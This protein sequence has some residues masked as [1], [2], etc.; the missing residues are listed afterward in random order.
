MRG[1]SALGIGAWGIVLAAALVGQTPSGSRDWNGEWEL[2]T[3]FFGEP[4]AERLVLKVEKGKV[5]GTLRHAGKSLPI[6]GTAGVGGDSIRFEYQGEDGS[7][8][9]YEGKQ[10]AAGDLA[11]R[12]T[13]MGGESWG[14]N[15]PRNWKARRAPVD[16]PAAPRTL[17]FEPIGFSRVFSA[18]VPPVLRIWPGD[19]VRTRTV[20]AAGVD[21]KNTTRALGGNPQTGP[22]YV[23]GAMPGDVL[24]VHVRKLGLNRATAISDNGLVDRAVTN[25]YAAEHKDDEQWKDVVWSLD[26]QRGVATLAKPPAR[27]KDLSV[28]LHPMLG[29][30]GVAPGFG[31]AAIRTGDSGR[32]GGNMD[33]SGIQEG[34]TVYLPVAQPGAL[35]YVGDGHALQG[36]G[37]LNGNALETSLDVE[38]TVDLIRE[39]SISAPRIED[40][41]SL[42]AIGLEGSLDEA[43]R[44]ATSALA[45]WLQQDYQLTGPETA[46]L[47][48]A[49]I[50][51]RIA[52]VADRNVGVVARIR[53]NRIPPAPPASP[54]TPT[55]APGKKR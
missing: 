37:E 44:E 33:F 3:L 6:T 36:D 16:K 34:A 32:F 20:D 41:E 1:L 51:Y 29:C 8:N 53:K 26:A 24:A 7:R 5:A 40:S 19:T 14:D 52:E 50:E 39:K 55:P 10:D 21:Q 47:L 22:F 45:Q 35:L 15:P 38:I 12:F 11:G 42:M 54:A 27:L 9:V 30:V 23:E 17:D 49:T 48:G 2:T 28:P 31:A 43:F 4:R 18:T 46:I 13:S 25:D